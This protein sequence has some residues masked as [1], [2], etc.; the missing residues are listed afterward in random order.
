MADTAAQ[1]L[2][3]Y[4]FEYKGFNFPKDEITPECIDSLED[5]EIRDSDVFIVT[6]PKSGTV[7]TQQILTLIYAEEDAAEFKTT[8]ERAPWL[9]FQE[10]G[11][12]YNARPSPR[13]FAS[14]LPYYLVPKALRN[15]K[16]KVIYIV[17]NPKDAMVSY[18]HFHNIMVKMEKTKDF[19]SFMDKYVN[20][21]VMCS[22]WFDHI[23]GWYSHRD[24]FEMLFMTYE[25]MIKDLRAAVLKICT[26]LGKRLED[27]AVDKIVKQ[28]TFKNMKNDPRAN[29]EFL[30]EDVMHKDRGRF[31]R[32]GT[33]GD[34]KNT[35]TVA[36]S[37]FFDKVFQQ[38]M[39]D[40]PLKFI[41][42]INEDAA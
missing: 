24:Q 38:K 34:W 33:I 4:T 31:L 36:Q 3:E 30:P 25:E 29:Y 9:E 23:R 1:S 37:E 42:D 8:Y 13:L 5:F 11:Q 22:S 12:D 39:K 27:S 16:A 32:K 7:W 28:A 41:W 15:K 20:G 10:K 19:S 18:F 26:F 2:D 17:R 14:H 35:F 6:Y 40:L 21:K